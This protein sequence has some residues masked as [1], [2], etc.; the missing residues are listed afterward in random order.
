MCDKP[1]ANTRL[2]RNKRGTFFLNARNKT[3][4]LHPLLFLN[5]V[6][7]VPSTA[8]RQEK[9]IKD[10][11]SGKEEVKLSLTEMTGDYRE[12]TLKSPPRKYQ[13]QGANSVKLQGTK[14][15]FRN[16]LYFYKSILNSQKEKLI[17]Q[18]HLQLHQKIKYLGK[19]LTRSK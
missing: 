9:E 18:S 8:L 11:Q 13:N 14:S 16:Q 5:T 17:K 4:K 6:L 1:T 19:N 12:R 2:N 7:E 10:I 3:R 15:T